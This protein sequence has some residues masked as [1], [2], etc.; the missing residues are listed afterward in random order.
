MTTRAHLASGATFDYD[1]ETCAHFTALDGDPVVRREFTGP[2]P[3][4]ALRQAGETKAEQRARLAAELAALDDGQAAPQAAPQ[5]A[6]AGG[7]FPPV[8]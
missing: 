5:P 6:G 1:E 3:A 2:T 7:L 4:R 8:S